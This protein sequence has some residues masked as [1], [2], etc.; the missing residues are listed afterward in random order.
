MFNHK[1]IL[2]T[3]KPCFLDC[4]QGQETSKCW[5]SLRYIKVQIFEIKSGIHVYQSV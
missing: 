2:Y 3:V 5:K 1:N 4:N